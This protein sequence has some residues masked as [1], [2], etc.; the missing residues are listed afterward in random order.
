MHLLSLEAAKS[1]FQQQGLSSLNVMN[2]SGSTSH[3]DIQG[4]LVVTLQ[5]QDGRKFLVDMGNAHGMRGCPTNLLSVSLL[6][7]I[8]CVVHFEHGNC[9]I[10]PP[11]SDERIPLV[12]EGG[13]FQLPLAGVSSRT[14]HP[15]FVSEHSF[16]ANGHSFLAGD[17][18][19][20]HRRLRHMNKDLIL[21]MANHNLVDGLNI[22]GN[23]NSRCGCMTCAQAKIRRQP[24]PQDR[25]YRDPAS[26]VDHTV[27]A[28]VKSVSFESLQG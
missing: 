6:I 18:D 17:L 25:Q 14:M 4:Q 15:E 2:V 12:R 22:I 28:D 9:Y 26:Y 20:W 23:K 3:A 27:S 13:L 1:L 16:S 11:N 5:A 8:G 19:L 7:D 24:T 21:K 10:Q